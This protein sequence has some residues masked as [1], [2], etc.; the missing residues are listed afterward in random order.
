MQSSWSWIVRS[1]HNDNHAMP[2]EYSTIL[3]VTQFMYIQALCN[4]DGFQ[5]EVLRK[6]QATLESGLL[7]SFAGFV[8]A[9]ADRMTAMAAAAGQ[10]GMDSARG[11]TR[12]SECVL[13]WQ[14]VIL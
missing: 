13:F 4:N 11:K 3:P 1:M 9:T 14:R 6:V 5:K 10:A 8:D 7:D 12:V 2:L